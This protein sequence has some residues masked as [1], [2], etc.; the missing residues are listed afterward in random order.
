[1]AGHQGRASIAGFTRRRWLQSGGAALASGIWP[2]LLAARS[3]SPAPAPAR[4][5]IIIYLQGGLSHYESFDPKPRAALEYR[6]EFQSIATSLP[7]IRFCEHMP[8]LAARAHRFNVIRS[9]FV[10]SPSH[11]HAIHSSLTGWQPPGSPRILAGELVRNKLHPAVGAVVARSRGAEHPGLPGYVTVPHAGQLGARV[12]Y[13]GAG[14]LG[15]QHEPVDSGMP[16]IRADQ[17]FTGPSDLQ[18]SSKLNRRRIRDRLTLLDGMQRSDFSPLELEGLGPYHRQAYEILS[19]GAAADAFNLS[20][21]PQRVREQYGQHLWGQQTVLARRLAEAGVP[22]TLMNFTLN[23]VKGQ[24]WDTHKDNFGLMK[25]VLLPPMDLAVSTLL[26]DLDARGLLDTTLVA[27]FGE[28]GRT[29]RINKDA[30]RD[31]WEKVFSVMLAGGGLKS[32][33]VLG[34]STRDGDLPLDRPVHL[35]DVLATIYHQLGVSCDEVIHDELDRPF[36][37]LPHGTAVPELL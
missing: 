18:L 20:A 10:D 33:I 1:M 24:D 36:P 23:Q 16:P 31:H 35:N 4:Q 11:E 2:S 32:G 6:G 37:V 14:M 15:V 13:A 9:T 12:H 28:F 3:A 30:G 7:G 25:D 34:S 27:M 17:P 5:A 8:R 21:E 19:G 29:P 22:L 26:D